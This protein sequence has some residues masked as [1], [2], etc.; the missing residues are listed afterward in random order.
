MI[1]ASMASRWPFHL[2]CYSS[3][4]S[5]PSFFM[6]PSTL[7]GVS[8]RSRKCIPA[9]SLYLHRH[10]VMN[11]TGACLQPKALALVKAFDRAA[12]R[13]AIMYWAHL[14]SIRLMRMCSAI[15]STGTSSPVM[16]D[17]TIL[18]AF[19]LLQPISLFSTECQELASL[20]PQYDFLC[21][22]PSG[23]VDRCNTSTQQH[24]SCHEGIAPM[25]NKLDEKE[26]VQ[27]AIA[28]P[29]YSCFIYLSHNVH[30]HI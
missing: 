1:L 20:K 10:T 29:T 7:L 23:A 11:L 9:H 18:P 6:A 28:F 16:G 24:A 17:T 27:T 26:G 14:G 15:C 30:I 5:G 22:P 21:N 19:P 4:P 13:Q 8:R 25:H 2:Q 12:T 3:K